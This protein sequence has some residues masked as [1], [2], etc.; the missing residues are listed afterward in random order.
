MNRLICYKTSN[1]NI[2]D[3]VGRTESIDGANYGSQSHFLNAYCSNNFYYR[4][5]TMKNKVIRV[6]KSLI[7]HFLLSLM[8]L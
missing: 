1:S 5:N 6:K 4:Q 3:P 7:M 8:I 2:S